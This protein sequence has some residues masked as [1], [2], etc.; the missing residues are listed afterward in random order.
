MRQV[1]GVRARWFAVVAA[2]VLAVGAWLVVV[3]SAE[4][5]YATGG[6]GRWRSLVN[7]ME[8]PGDGSG[9]IS[10][11]AQASTTQQFGGHTLRTTC[12]LTNIRADD[13]AGDIYRY[14]SGSWSGDALDDLYNIG[15]TGT[16]NQLVAG[17]SN[18]TSPR[19]PGT[20]SFHV[21]CVATLDGEQI[22][23]SGLV[24][25]DAEQ[26]NYQPNGQQEWIRATPDDPSGVTWRLLERARTAGC[27][28]GT[29]LTRGQADESMRM[30]STA[31]QCSGTPGGP[32]A[33]TYMEHASSATFDVNSSNG[34][35]SALALGTVSFIDFGDA[36]ESYGVAAA[37]SDGVIQGGELAYGSTQAFNAGVQEAAMGQPTPR[38]GARVDPESTQLFSADALGDDRAGVD[39]E[40][41]VT[42]PAT[43]EATRGQPITSPPIECHGPGDVV[44]W[45]DWNRNG[46]FDESE[47][48][49][50]E[51]CG[52]DGS[53]AVT[54]Q[55]PADAAVGTGTTFVR[56]R[57][58]DPSEEIGPVGPTLTGEVEDY[59]VSVRVVQGPVAADDRSEGNEIGAPVKVA[60]LANDEGDLDPSTL[61]LTDP[62]GDPV[63]ELVVPGEG[64]WSVG[65]DGT[66]TFT[67]E[68]GFEGNPTPVDYTVEDADGLRTGASV[69]VTYAPEAT[70][71]ES[72]DNPR[73]STVRI[74][75][76]A[77]DKGDLDPSTLRLTDPAG[78]PVTELVV[79]GEGTW[80]VGG[81]GTITFTPERGFEG[82]PTPVGYTVEDRAGQEVGAKITVTYDPGPTAHPDQTSGAQGAP[83]S[84]DPL[85]NDERGPR[86]AAL[87]PS[88]LTLLD[89]EG[90]PV[91]SLTVPGEGTFT[92]SDGK[93]VF[94]P[95]PGFVGE[96]TPVRYRVAD[97][98]GATA[99]ST[100]TPTVTPVAQP[101][102]SSGPQGVPQSVD[103]LANDDADGVALDP[104]TLTLVDADGNP[105]S[106]LT[107]PGEGTY[108]VS[109][110]K[111]VF[112]P[113][114]G[115][116]GEATPVRY[117]VEDSE[118]NAVESTYTP[119]VTAVRPSANPDTTSGPQG[120]PQSV[121]PLVN[122]EA[123]DD[124][125]P[126]DPESLTLLD[127]DGNP[128]S[129]VTVPGEGVYTVSDGKLVFT[130]EPQFNGEATPVR[131]Q[132]ADVNGTTAESTYT[133]TITPVAPT[134]N[135]DTTSG[136]QGVPQSVDPLAN[137]EAGD[138]A[139]PLD[140][141]SLTLLDA[142]GNPVSSVT[143]PG[144]GVYTVSDGKLVF[145]PEPQFTGEATPV[146][147]QVADVNGTT[148]ES[149]YTPTITPVSP[150]ANPD[151]TTGPQ[152]QPQSID[153]LAND[154]AGDDA[155]PLDPDSLTLLDDNGDPVDSVTVP[156]EGTYT[157][158]DGKLVFTPEPQFTGEATP[159]RYQ[160]ADVNGTTAESTYTPTLTPVTPKANPDET[161]GPQGRPQSIDP[162]AND[163]AGDEAVPLDPASLTLLDDNGAPTDSVT[164]PGEGTYTV[165]DGKLVFTPEPQFTG[166]ATPVRYQVADVNGTTAE[167]T[168]MP[169]VTPVA[170]PDTTSGPQ[171]VPQSVDP[172]ANDGADGVELD[173]TTLTLVDDDGNPADAVT[174]P[175]EG[176]YT[177]EDGKLVFTPEPDFTGTATP[178]RYR[179][180]DAEGNTVEST[181]TPT[182]R[183]SRRPR[184]PTRRPGRRAAP[185]ASTR[186]PTTRRATRRSRST[187][188]RSPCSTA[189]VTRSTRSPCPARASTRSRTARSCSRPSRTS[190]APRRRSTTRSPT[191]T[192]PPR[193]RRTHRRW[194]PTGPASRSTRRPAGTPT[195]RRGA[196]RPATRSSTG[197]GSPTPATRCSTTSRS[198]TRC[199]AGRWRAG[200]VRWRRGRPGTA[201]T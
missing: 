146:R 196:G 144:E 65:D 56:V 23:L 8:W 180:D 102:T 63:T 69:T 138:D 155:V 57:I 4:A 148:A 169:T 108:T 20:M 192:G 171:G 129:S 181:Y 14:R 123:G 77:N 161:S 82:D 122:D 36:P 59:R 160:V 145:T 201:P 25:A 84:V 193:G 187:P 33:L 66:I 91:S 186:S 165:D 197:S 158:E 18:G 28:T 40:D 95:E 200:P 176:T 101:D 96:A 173:P 114:P 94:T 136:P 132:V 162:L 30:Q 37:L 92:L 89:D 141:K 10:N 58:A 99:E 16:N 73:G 39:D 32:I 43:V 184:T 19:N 179:V 152:G 68:P 54:W 130:P 188:R 191:S 134:A 150:S 61:R 24:F 163:E 90:N 42:F 183:R 21:D 156:G 71:D 98:N 185:R 100:Y 46:R 75:P 164:V 97:V 26:N 51:P 109:D 17:I 177:V 117:Q 41:A 125:V 172:L 131:Y 199:W 116:V 159:V 110:G 5:R 147:Y 112:T 85:A 1:S 105:V 55:V 111:L 15:G 135:P 31:T 80:S 78:D 13:G 157:V 182:L 79:P 83:Q 60:V 12:T 142:D 9:R 194:R 47:R 93:L 107:V 44:A 178:V 167:S 50:T 81:D 3:D 143:V 190:P 86:D 49:T 35:V 74:D 121:D 168:Y 106:S 64:T 29:W 195:S 27:G 113:E 174:V 133:P 88:S 198:T 153:P 6:S 70:D 103:P 22:P 139:V 127:E 72:R 119:T 124:A 166:E 137:D 67:P 140:P 11:G 7:W 170:Q 53:V 128:V 120:V 104:S 151:T 115:F 45:F 126:L 52:T 87:D 175:G 2:G 118:G 154:E 48:S 189:T 62:A 38:L 149:T 34:A 76:L